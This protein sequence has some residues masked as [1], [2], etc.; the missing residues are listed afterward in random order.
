MLENFRCEVHFLDVEAVFFFHPLYKTLT[1]FVVDP[2]N[3]KNRSYIKDFTIINYCTLYVWF[4]ILESHAYDATHR[5]LWQYIEPAAGDF[6][7]ISF[8]VMCKKHCIQYIT[9]PT[10]PHPL[11]CRRAAAV[12]LEAAFDEISWGGTAVPPVFVAG[13]TAVPP[14]FVAGGTTAAGAVSAAY[15]KTLE[16]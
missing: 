4:D 16:M 12:V 3:Q 1:L 14:V 5:K 7:Y 8:S 2:M 15:K 13:G 11:L 10:R 9:E 6:V